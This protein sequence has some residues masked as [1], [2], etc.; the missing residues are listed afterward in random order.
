M[1]ITVHKHP[2]R[3][4]AVVQVHAT[5]DSW[6]G[7][8]LFITTGMSPEQIKA[9]HDRIVAHHGA[10][11]ERH[12][13]FNRLDRDVTGFHIHGLAIV[14]QGTDVRL[15][16]RVTTPSGAVL[17][18]DRIAPTVADLPSDVEIAAIV[19]EAATAWLSR[20]S[21]ADGHVEDVKSILGLQ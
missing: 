7:H 21:G 14:E 12:A 13:G 2:T 6:H 11:S 3:N 8:Y 18:L 4:A 17:R 1:N 15:V 10:K 9:E 16:L 19:R 20:E 5:D